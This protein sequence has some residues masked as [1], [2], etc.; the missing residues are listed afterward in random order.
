MAFYYGFK[1]NEK[2]VLGTGAERDYF[3]IC[4]TCI[5]LLSY[6]SYF[7]FYGGCYS[8][9]GT[10]KITIE[11]FVLVVFGRIDMNRKLHAC[12]FM[13]TS[14]ETKEDYEFF[15]SPLKQL[16]FELN[17]ICNNFQK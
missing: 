7:Q 1:V 8:I 2:I 15:Y 11:N 4:F 5:K 3:R 12:A 9:D 14:H 16:C 6:V 17:Y 10:Y 13:V